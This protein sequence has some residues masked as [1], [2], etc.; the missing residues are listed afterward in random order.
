MNYEFA[1]NRLKS[2]QYRAGMING[3]L[4]VAPGAEGD[5]PVLCSCSFQPN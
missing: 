2:V 4:E 1:T 5:T 3:R